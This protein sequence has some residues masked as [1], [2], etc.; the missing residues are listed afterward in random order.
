MIG[1]PFPMP[2][3]LAVGQAFLDGIDSTA[4]TFAYG[5]DLA[6][7]QLCPMDHTGPRRAQAQRAAAVCDSAEA[8]E[9]DEP[10]FDGA[11]AGLRGAR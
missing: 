8:L 1:L 5:I 10:T 4:Q 3:M 6:A 2:L 7:R 11:H 9:D